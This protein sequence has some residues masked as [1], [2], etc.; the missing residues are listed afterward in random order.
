MLERITKD[1]G[2]FKSRPVH[3]YNFSKNVREIFIVEKDT[4]VLIRYA[5]FR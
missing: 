3:I 2:G 1:K 4:E 5:Q